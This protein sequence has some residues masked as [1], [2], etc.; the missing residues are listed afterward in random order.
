MTLMVT[1]PPYQASMLLLD[2]SAGVPLTLSGMPSDDNP[3][4]RVFRYNNKIA[5]RIKEE[6]AR[7]DLDFLVVPNELFRTTLRDA[8]GCSLS[9][10]YRHCPGGAH[11]SGK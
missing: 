11:S 8:R 9:H 4:A 1:L 7:C 3:T 6:C 10:A 5:R 2:S